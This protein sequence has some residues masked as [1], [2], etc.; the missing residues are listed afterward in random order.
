M[1]A[2]ASSSDWKL[3]S[4]SLIECGPPHRLVRSRS[5]SWQPP[6]SSSSSSTLLA[7]ASSDATVRLWTVDDSV[8]GGSSKEVASLS[9]SSSGGG[10]G[11]DQPVL[12][13]R[14]HPHSQHRDRLASA[15][16]TQVR[17][18]DVRAPSNPVVQK[19]DGASSSS[20]NTDLQWNPVHAHLLAVAER[21][22]TVRVYDTR[23]LK[24]ATTGQKK[25]DAGTLAIH[26]CSLG[27]D[28]IPET[29]AWDPVT[30]DYLVAG[31]TLANGMG[32]LK[33]WNWQKQDDDNSSTIVSYPAH[34]G[35]IYALEFAPDGGRL[36]TGGA[37]AVVGLW[38]APTLCCHHTVT[39]RL[40]FIRGLSYA[41]PNAQLLAIA[42][43]EADD[44]VDL[45]DAAT[46]APV[47]RVP[48]GVRPRSGGAE[49]VAFGPT[50]TSSGSNSHKYLLAIARTDTGMPTAPVAVAQLTVVRATTTTSR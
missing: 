32:A 46:G 21:S 37:D 12:R 3:S 4:S 39:R 17:L 33:I 28:N 22:G 45:A 44:G 40:K 42:T 27:P 25:V 34:A 8:S 26:S 49:C 19:L 18:W 50:T 20:K 6:A 2:A 47:G 43:E 16:A 15:A 10:G 36:A 1:T 38:D 9:S 48:L 23:Q 11:H 24:T 14:F 41:P 30:G 35:P 31:T 13:V 7:V 29:I 5:V